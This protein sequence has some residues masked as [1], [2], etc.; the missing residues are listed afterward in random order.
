MSDELPGV[1]RRQKVILAVIGVTAAARIA[2]DGRIH[3]RVVV[4]AIVL[5]A[6]A[7]I[8]RSSEAHS[9]ERL[10]AWDKQR[11]LNEQ[12]RAEKR[13]TGRWTWAPDDREAHTAGVI[14]A[15]SVRI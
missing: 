9:V 5:A 2:R 13:K 15:R 8:A 11:T 3:E 14:P 12:R 4:L 10:T 7:G 6:V 1:S